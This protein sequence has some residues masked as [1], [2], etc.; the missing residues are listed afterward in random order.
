[1]CNK[2]TKEKLSN[3]FVQCKI[4]S[5]EANYETTNL[6]DLSDLYHR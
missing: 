5:P 2:F 6:G 4:Q 1:M 3:A